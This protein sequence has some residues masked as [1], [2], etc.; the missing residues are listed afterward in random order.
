MAYIGNQ[1]AN[2]YTSFDSQSLTGDGTA[3]GCIE[4][5]TE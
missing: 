5:K 2:S 1:P 3:N 4:T